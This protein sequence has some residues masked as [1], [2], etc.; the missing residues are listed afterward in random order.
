MGDAAVR[1][2]RT[3]QSEMPLPRLGA[4]A[5]SRSEARG[6]RRGPARRHEEGTRRRKRRRCVACARLPP[7]RN[8]TLVRSATVRQATTKKCLAVPSPH[9]LGWIDSERPLQGRRAVSARRVRRTKGSPFS[10]GPREIPTR[11][12]PERRLATVSAPPRTSTSR[13]TRRAA[14]TCRAFCVAIAR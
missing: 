5:P 9:D 14:G 11:V 2:T 1:R 4:H 3:D 6:A 8:R 7:L 12:P 10:L 13:A